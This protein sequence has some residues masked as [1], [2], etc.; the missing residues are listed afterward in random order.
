MKRKKDLFL[1]EIPG[2]GVGEGG[3]KK[4]CKVTR[5]EL[6][7]ASVNESPPASESDTQKRENFK[8]HTSAQLIRGVVNETN[9]YLIAKG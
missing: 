7:V 3:E 4:N 9:S 6:N 2:E 5:K 8:V 1:I